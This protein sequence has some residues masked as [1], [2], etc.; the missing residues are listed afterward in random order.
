MFFFLVTRFREKLIEVSEKIKE[1]N[2]SRS[3]YLYYDYLD[4]EFIPNSIAVW[5]KCTLRVNF[6]L[7]GG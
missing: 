6:Y 3:K 4:P 7:G 1:R 2:K 5:L